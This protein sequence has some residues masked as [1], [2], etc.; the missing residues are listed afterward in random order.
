MIKIETRPPG[1]GVAPAGLWMHALPEPALVVQDGQ[2]CLANE[3]AG[4]LFGASPPSLFGKALGTLLLE[5]GDSKGH[6]GRLQA[7]RFDGALRWVDAARSR[8]PGD[9]VQLVLL[10][11]VT[12]QEGH[13]K[14]LRESEAALRRLALR[15]NDR[16]EEARHRLARRVHDELQQSL[17]ALRY[18]CEG[19]RLAAKVVDDGVVAFLA[20]TALAI[21]RAIDA[22]ARIVNELRPSILEELGLPA[23]LEALTSGFQ[24][25]TGIAARWRPNGLDA[26]TG[27]ENLSPRH[28]TC[29]YRVA[30]E[31]LT[32]VAR[33]ARARTVVVSLA[34]T[35]EGHVHL[36]VRD[37][38][39]GLDAD[40]ALDNNAVG[41]VG[42]H[43]HVRS[44]GGQF[45]VRA[46]N[47]GGT[48]VHAIVPPP[49]RRLP[50]RQGARPY[51][52]PPG[53]M[54]QRLLDLFYRLPIGLVE[55]AA[56]GSIRTINPRA[57][58]WLQPALRGNRDW[59]LVTLLAT[60][61]PGLRRRLAD[62]RL[63]HPVSIKFSPDG[64]RRAT[65]RITLQRSADGGLVALLADLQP[66][67]RARTSQRAGLPRCAAGRLRGKTSGPA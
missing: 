63:G 62:M 36:R 37:D 44:L 4:L 29:L 60:S 9:E 6:S 13:L 5:C 58:Q 21:D 31:A 12:D 27:V 14:S 25:R 3:P 56:D 45:V 59:N 49:E 2:V 28:A 16:F 50:D 42:L 26:E 40:A 47:A 33:H 34:R 41:L 20:R 35:R 8:L 51:A 38:G 46:A 61:R 19:Q 52:A 17:A 10:H 66:A 24:R 48:L 67:F 23:A 55:A 15:Q 11:D 43:E 65:V 7:R 39:V 57:A 54:A 22:A 53:D 32:N 64:R 1:S 18:E 30:E